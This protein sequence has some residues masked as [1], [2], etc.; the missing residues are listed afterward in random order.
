MAT[1]W[2][3]MFNEGLVCLRATL[4]LITMQ[5]SLLPS[6]KRVKEKPPLKINLITLIL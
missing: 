1:G 3:L 4:L 5:Q 6:M 2:N